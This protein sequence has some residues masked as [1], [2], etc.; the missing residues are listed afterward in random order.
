V[1]RRK[2][3]RHLT[4]LDAFVAAVE[5]GSL[6]GAARHLGVARSVVSEHLRALEEAVTDGQ[7][8][9]ERSPGRRL[10]LTAQGEKLYAAAQGPLHQLELRRL[11][12]LASPEPSVRLGLNQTLS[13]LLL[14]RL[15]ER[16]AAAGLRLECALGGAHE[17]V[18][19]VQTRQR[20]LALGFS[21]LPPHQGVSFLSLARLAFV[22]LAAP[23]SPLM[24]RPGPSLSVKDLDRQRFVDWLRTDPYGGANAARFATAGIEVEEVARVEGMLQLYP[25]L[26]AYRACAIAPDL[27]ALAPPPADFQVWRLRERRPQAVEVVALWPASGLRPEAALL[28]EALKGSIAGAGRRGT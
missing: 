26:R 10:Q 21:P 8:L 24:R 22:V 13:E 12:D 23:G 4:W 3:P 2:L 11:R 27:R 17:L 6:E 19:D 9:L 18:R 25:C 15:V 7:L 16:A 20:D 28:L 5:T 14:P 1:A